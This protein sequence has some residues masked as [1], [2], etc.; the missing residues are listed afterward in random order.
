MNGLNGATDRM[1]QWRN[2]T[3]QGKDATSRAPGMQQN[4]AIAMGGEMSNATGIDAEHFRRPFLVLLREIF[5][6][7]TERDFVLD[8]G[9]SLAETLSDIS[10][11]EASQRVSTQTASVA[12]QVNHLCVYVEAIISGDPGRRVDWD[13]TWNDAATVND[14]EWIALVARARENFEKMD[15]FCATFEGWDEPFIGGAMAILAHTMYHLGEIRTGIG[16][17]R[18]RRT[19]D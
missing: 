10:A 2:A 17:V 19:A 8:G 6:G 9:T 7:G 12:A 3:R 15:T 1:F 13:A 16:V 14:A 4:V 5:V 11:E 18:E